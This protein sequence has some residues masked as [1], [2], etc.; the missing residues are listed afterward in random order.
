MGTEINDG[1][2][3]VDL[4]D[5][6]FSALLDRLERL[7][8]AVPAELLYKR[9]PQFTIGECVLRSAALIEQVSGGLTTNLWDDPFEWTLPETL[10]DSHRI[11]DYLKEVAQARRRMF[12]S[13]LDES[14]LKYVAVPSRDE[15]T[16]MSLLIESLIRASDY[17]GRAIATMK[18]LSDVGARG[19]II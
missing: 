4:L 7:V 6:E 8:E 18:L 12:N 5:R 19:V 11:V 3:T 17:R 10:S 15:R 13:L 2:S 16:V 14:L 1:R 9:P